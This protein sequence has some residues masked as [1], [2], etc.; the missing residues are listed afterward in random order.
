MKYLT[1]ISLL[2]ILSCG[3]ETRIYQ[4]NENI[5]NYTDFQHKFLDKQF[6]KLIGK[7]SLFKAEILVEANTKDS[8]VLLDSVLCYCLAICKKESIVESR[9]YKKREG[10]EIIKKYNIEKFDA[11]EINSI[12]T[13]FNDSEIFWKSGIASFKIGQLDDNWKKQINSDNIST[14]TPRLIQPRFTKKINKRLIVE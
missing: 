5:C 14:L 7:D 8:M 9:F 6:I 12:I 1:I 13:D 3:I 11:I 10:F 2:L 4:C